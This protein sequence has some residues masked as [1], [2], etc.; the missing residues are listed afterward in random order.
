MKRYLG[1][2]ALGAI[3]AP[4]PASA[5]ADWR[6]VAHTETSVGHGMGY[7][8]AESISRSEGRVTFWAFVV[9]ERELAGMDNVRYHVDADC[10]TRSFRYLEAIFY[11]RAAYVGTV[12]AEDTIESAP[13]TGAYDLV[14]TACGN[15]TMDGLAVEDPY[16]TATAALRGPDE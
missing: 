10:E 5:A 13:G 8:D 9:F 7:I 16:A 15:R 4:A 1:L 3:L 12:R 11:L 14:D 6:Y 2:F